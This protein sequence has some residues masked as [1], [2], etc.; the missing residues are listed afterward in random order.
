LETELGNIEMM[1]ETDR[2]PLSASAFLK[3]VD[4]GT[5]TRHGTFYRTVRK[6]ENDHGRPEIDVVQ[7]GWQD[8]PDT[9]VKINHEST[10]QTGLQHLDGAV[11]LARG[12]LNTA[13]GAAFFICIGAQPALDAGGGRNQDGQG[14][15]AFGRVTRGMDTVR[16]IHQRPTS[17]SSGD[18]YTAGQMLDPPVRILKVYR[19]R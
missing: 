13:T 11:S 18:P 4:E 7:G 15:A 8:A 14:F 1:L 19:A 9:L 12:G 3:L 17:A 10:E 5:F 6:N 2:A 16:K